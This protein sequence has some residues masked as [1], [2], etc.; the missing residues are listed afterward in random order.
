VNVVRSGVTG[1]DDVVGDRGDVVTDGIGCLERDAICPPQYRTRGSGSDRYRYVDP[2]PEIP[3]PG[4][5]EA[6]WNSS[7]NVTERGG[8]PVIRDAENPP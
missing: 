6:P 7:V 1:H 3:E 5:R 2:I 8:G 4:G